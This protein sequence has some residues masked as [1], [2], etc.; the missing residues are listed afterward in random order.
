MS[1]NPTKMR[2]MNTSIPVANWRQ[3][4]FRLV[5]MHILRF[6]HFTIYAY[7]TMDGLRYCVEIAVCHN[8][9]DS[10]PDPHFRRSAPVDDW[11]TLLRTLHGYFAADRWRHPFFL[12]RHITIMQKVMPRLNLLVHNLTQLVPTRKLE[13]LMT[14]FD[15]LGDVCRHYNSTKFLRHFDQLRV[16]KTTVFYRD[17]SSWCEQEDAISTESFPEIQ[18]LLL[19]PGIYNP[20]PDHPFLDMGHD[21]QSLWD[22]A[23]T[24]PNLIDIATNQAY[25]QLHPTPRP[26][27]VGGPFINRAI[28]S[29]DAYLV[30]LCGSK[31]AAMMTLKPPIVYCTLPN[32]NPTKEYAAS[33]D[34]HFGTFLNNV[35][36]FKYFVEAKPCSMN[37]IVFWMTGAPVFST[38]D[39]K[40]EWEMFDQKRPTLSVF[41]CITSSKREFKW[42]PEEVDEE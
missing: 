22:F 8:P 20:H 2:K 21:P 28:P 4:P 10:L 1:A 40:A 7:D 30:P 19:Y 15:M 35:Y 17:G 13:T 5:V 9:R 33:H 42:L 41:G 39:E 16:L 32:L 18:R 3:L 23:L 27:L 11:Q 37:G 26:S 14:N 34:I 6:L 25:V 31:E 12:Y 36:H 38:A 24:R 29:L